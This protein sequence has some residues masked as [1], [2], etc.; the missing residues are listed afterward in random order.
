MLEVNFDPFPV[1]ETERC[2]LRK[3][4]LKDTNELFELRRNKIVL[5]HLF[6]LEEKSLEE[7]EGVIKEYD[8]VIASNEKIIWAVT[9][10]GKD[11]LV[12]TIGFRT[13]TKEHYRAE[14]GYSL[15]PEFHR[16]GIMNEVV[17]AIVDF[18]FNRLGLHSLEASVDPENIASIKL[19]GKNGFVKEAHY[20]ENYYFKGTFIDS[21]IYCLVNSEN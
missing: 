12:G 8:R 6:R 21:A 1:I 13:I 4:I 14:F 3:I 9:F 17:K 15:M 2:L 16:K 5:K 7:I 10:K 18:S 19:L 20:K 11:K